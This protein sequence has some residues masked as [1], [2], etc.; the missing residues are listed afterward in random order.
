LTVIGRDEPSVYAL[1]LDR[2]RLAAGVQFHGIALR[3]LVVAFNAFYAESMI[4]L[5]GFSDRNR[6]P[7][8]PANGSQPTRSE[9]DR[10]PPAAGSRR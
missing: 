6:Q 10:T 7:G 9:I 5:R 4:W 8:G 1:S 3:P 2:N